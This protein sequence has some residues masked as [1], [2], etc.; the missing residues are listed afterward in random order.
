MFAR[1]GSLVFET[2]NP[3]LRWDGTTPNGELCPEGVYTYR[4]LAR[5]YRGQPLERSG[6]VTLLR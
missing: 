4:I 1:D 2:R 6:T 5:N 3:N